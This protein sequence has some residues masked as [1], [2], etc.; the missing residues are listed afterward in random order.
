MI[1]FRSTRKFAKKEYALDFKILP[2]EVLV[3]T[4]D[5][6]YL[7][8]E[9]YIS[10]EEF[11]FVQDLSNTTTTDNKPIFTT[12]SGKIS[13]ASKNYQDG[14]DNAQKDLKNSYSCCLKM[15][16]QAALNESTT[17][18]PSAAEN[19]S[20][21][22]NFTLKNSEISTLY[23]PI[24]ASKNSSI[25]AKNSVALAAIKRISERMRSKTHLSKSRVKSLRQLAILRSAVFACCKRIMSNEE[26]VKNV[27]TKLKENE[28][29]IAKYIP[30]RKAK[31]TIDIKT[32]STAMP[33]NP[34]L[35]ALL[36]YKY[37]AR[38]RIY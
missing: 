32:D 38:N 18:L 3:E 17:I 12:Y 16:I 6:S 4:V 1:P 2:C 28:L 30:R 31:L 36:S 7:M 15:P 9:V 35:N 25:S 20:Q 21:A 8:P 19:T 11:D 29:E 34:I 37:Q 26:V 22:K 5:L 23:N 24:L 14:T 10:L 33:V 27:F 13:I